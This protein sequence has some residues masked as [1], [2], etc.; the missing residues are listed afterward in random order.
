M[1][2]YRKKSEIVEAVQWDGIFTD[3]V[4]PYNVLQYNPIAPPVCFC[5]C[6]MPLNNHG[7][8]TT[9]NWEH[10]VCIGD[11]IVAQEGEE[12]IPVKPDNF[13]RDYEPVDEP[14]MPDMPVEDEE[15]TTPRVEISEWFLK[16]RA[17]MDRLTWLHEL[18]ERLPVMMVMD[19]PITT[20]ELAQTLSM[21]KKWFFK[22]REQRLKGKT[23]VS[24]GP[25]YIIDGCKILYRPD[26]VMAWIDA[27]KAFVAED[28]VED[29]LIM[30]G[31][32]D[33]QVD[34]DEGEA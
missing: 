16:L 34:F 15:V 2:K 30:E 9:L 24:A 28:P 4:R 8:I 12:T 1:A 32:L 33:I 27:L 7:Y 18:V 21:E 3:D 11:W 14:S 6:G 10:T 13:K 31:S 29:M 20:A 5:D 17:Y 19:R 22:M 25:A 23:G 26:D